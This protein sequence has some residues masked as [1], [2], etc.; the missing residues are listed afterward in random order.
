[1]RK[2]KKVLISG[3]SIAGPTLAFW[4]SK[5]GFIVTVIERSDALRLG[6]QNIDISGPAQKIVQK[7]GIEAAIRAANT[8]EVGLQFVGHDNQPKASF[9]KNTELTWTQELEI[10]RGDLVQILYDNTKKNVTY[11][12]GDWIVGI[13]QDSDKVNVTFASGT[14]DKFDLVIIAEGTR[15]STRE[16]VFGKKPIFKYLG[17]YM[18]YLT[19]PRDKN[20][21]KWWRWYNAVDSRVLMLRPDNHGTMRA[22]VAFLEDE[23]GYEKLSPEH[24]KKILKSRLEGAGWEADRISKAIDNSD[25]VFLD[26]IGQIKAPKWSVGR[27]A[28]I[29]DAAYCP[30]PLTGKGT[31]LAMVGAYLLA[32][33]LARHENHEEAFAAY[34]KRMRPYV[35][36]VQKLPPGIPW[37]VYPKTSF[38]VS[39][40][41]F[42]AGI[43]ASHL[44]QKLVKLFT[45]KPKEK[46]KEEIELPDFK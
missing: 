25:D 32:G 15:S 11:Q 36:E 45:P 1:M 33:E 16:L 13:E 17:L 34:E 19:I 2:S 8:G 20:D 31:T 3:A 27:V 14:T 38:G 43:F 44:I 5:A 37:I 21:N 46:S 22:S 41:N 7:M 35:E 42:F 24:Q 12:F 23:K 4:L 10:I 39:V 40:L 9:P 26:K 28:M 29:G 30:T 6:G 18:A